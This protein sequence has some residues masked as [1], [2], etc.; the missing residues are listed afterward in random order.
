[1]DHWDRRQLDSQLRE[2]VS[3]DRGPYYSVSSLVTC[4]QCYILGIAWGGRV[5]RSTR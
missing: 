1:M 4:G 2:M 3:S 5:D